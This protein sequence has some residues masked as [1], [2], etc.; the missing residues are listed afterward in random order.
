MDW[1]FFFLA[2]KNSN[3]VMVVETFQGKNPKKVA[4]GLINMECLKCLKRKIKFKAGVW[5][6]DNGTSHWVIWSGLININFNW[7]VQ[8]WR[9]VARQWHLV[10]SDNQTLG[11]CCWSL[12][13]ISL[14][15]NLKV[16]ISFCWSKFTLEKSTSHHTCSYTYTRNTHL[17]NLNYKMKKIVPR[18]PNVKIPKCQNVQCS[19]CEK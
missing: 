19:M 7:S 5:L 17:S 14:I 11:C 16:F 10:W 8:S 18:Y 6:Q 3:N 9:L 15:S 1:V 4:F 12:T 2:F 13:T